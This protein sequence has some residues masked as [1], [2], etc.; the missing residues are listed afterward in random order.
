M[1]RII[2]IVG[3][4]Y[5]YQV[6]ETITLTTY[7]WQNFT[8]KGISTRHMGALFPRGLLSITGRRTQVK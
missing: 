1:P 5:G 7:H 8:I 6:P 2:P 3:F 4:S